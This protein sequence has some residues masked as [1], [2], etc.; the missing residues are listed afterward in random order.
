MVT[1]PD[2][3]QYMILKKGSGQKPLLTDKVKVHYTGSTIDGKVFD[4]SVQR[5]KPVTFPL[6]QVIPGWQEAIQL[7]P[8]G[9]KWRIFVPSELAYGA[10]GS[11]GVIEPYSTLIFDV[12]LL[13]IEK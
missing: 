5:G 9:S 7:M 1:L 2:G 8:V 12:E 4:S 13:G 6:N 3:L 11:Q 10:Q